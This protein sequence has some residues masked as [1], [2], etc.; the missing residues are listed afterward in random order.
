MKKMTIGGLAAV[1]IAGVIATAGTAHAT[2][3]VIDDKGDY[4]PYNFRDELRYAGIVHEDVNNAAEL[5]PRICRQRAEG[6][7]SSWLEDD[8]ISNDYTVEQ[9][10]A[11]VRGAEW[12][13]CSTYGKD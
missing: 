1:A 7:S 9:A 6:Y 8:L 5:G 2:G 11:I 13:F 3:A 10:V 12:H 4:D